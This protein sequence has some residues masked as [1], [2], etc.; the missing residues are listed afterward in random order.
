MIYGVFPRLPIE[1]GF[2]HACTWVARGEWGRAARRPPQC[3][4]DLFLL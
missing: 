1:V 2:T 3:D 4:V